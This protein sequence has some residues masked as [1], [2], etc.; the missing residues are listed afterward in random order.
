MEDCSTTSS[1]GYLFEIDRDNT[2]TLKVSDDL[3]MS[4][5]QAKERALSE[6]LKNSYVTKRKQFRTYR[7]DININDVINV[8]GLPFLVK[9]LGASFGSKDIVVSVSAQ[10]YE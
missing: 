6:M 3:L 5:D 4:E 9:Q 7:T 1:K 10:R 2:G 8:K